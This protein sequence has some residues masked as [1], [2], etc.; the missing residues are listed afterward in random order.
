MAAPIAQLDDDW[1]NFSSFSVSTTNDVWHTELD[2]ENNM[3]P[4][5]SVGSETHD[6]ID[7]LQFS[8]LLHYE[9]MEDLVNSFDEKLALCFHLKHNNKN[10]NQSKSPICTMDLFSQDKL[11]KRLTDNYG[12]VQP[13][14]WKTSSIRKLH[15][16]SLCL[17]FHQQKKSKDVTGCLC[18]N[19]NE[20][21]DDDDA[22]EQ[23]I[24]YHNMIEYNIYTEN[25]EIFEPNCVTGNAN[26]KIVQTADQVI[27]EL[28]EIMQNADEINAAVNYEIQEET[29]IIFG[30]MISCDNDNNYDS[31]RKRSCRSL[32]SVS[33]LEESARAS[34]LKTLSLSELNS[35]FQ[36]LD[37]QI[38]LLSTELL[39]ELEK[40]DELVSEIETKHSFI[41]KVME[42]QYKKEECMKS[43]KIRS[44]KKLS[45]LRI[46]N[47]S[48]AP[49][50]PGKYLTT[51]IPCNQGDV[52]TT[53]NLRSL[54]KILDAMKID[55]DEVPSLLTAYILQVICPA[56]DELHVLK[57]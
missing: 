4:Q 7:A 47:R 31:N 45:N 9:S 32:G 8:E 35:T 16:P 22:L 44:T 26:S 25:G 43:S 34:G 15:I 23:E 19:S 13:L 11:W 1:E 40:R 36:D 50:L 56:P 46:T 21:I 55:S 42:V 28:E 6:N 51:V 57:L 49:S 3:K 14:N 48:D 5:N 2:N 17:P 24:D 29:G 18:E 20:K 52:L 39:H 37:Q 53:D 54:I 10:N 38:H 30:E 27:E 33:S 12:L 41:S